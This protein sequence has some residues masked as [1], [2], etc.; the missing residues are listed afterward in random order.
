MAC[1]CAR[2]NVASAGWGGYRTSVS[3]GAGIG[4]A[5]TYKDNVFGMQKRLFSLPNGEIYLEN[6]CTRKATEKVTKM[7]I[8]KTQI[9]IDQVI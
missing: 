7:I 3:G 9:N 6:N 4:L 2:E 8:R 1:T 5:Y